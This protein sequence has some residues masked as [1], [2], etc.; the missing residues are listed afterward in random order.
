MKNLN[1]CDSQDFTRS[2]WIP[3]DL[4]YIQLILKDV[5][6]L[7]YVDTDILFLRPVEDIWRFLSGFNSS[8][9]AAMAPEHEEPRIGWYN[10]FARHPYHGR[11]GVNSGVMLMNLT[12]IRAKHFKVLKHVICACRFI[13]WLQISVQKWAIPSIHNICDDLH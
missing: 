8:H 5:D 12:R 11:T 9:V 6:S 3:S 13:M 10:R 2:D 7:L 1:W 4:C